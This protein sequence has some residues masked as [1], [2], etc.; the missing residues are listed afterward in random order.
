M[1]EEI[2]PATGP[3][4]PATG[5]K[6]FQVW[7]NAN[8]DDLIICSACCCNWCGVDL[9]CDPGC[10]LCAYERECICEEQRCCLKADIELFPLACDPCCDLECSK[11]G[12]C[13]TWSCL[14]FEYSW[15]NPKV[16]C[17]DRWS[18]LCVNGQT[19]FPPT[20]T[21]PMACI[22]CYGLCYCYPAC[23]VCPSLAKIRRDG[24][25]V[26]MAQQQQGVAMAPPVA[27]AVQA[28]PAA[29][30]QLATAP[31]QKSEV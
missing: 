8:E 10:F 1:S 13:W 14:F 15:K 24:G 11:D 6:N 17:G 22:Q 2:P 28:T 5:V 19:E 3:S 27:V 18:C 23:G 31:I 9:S 30:Q 25:Q 7:K 29:P 12:Y 20:A 26:P 16:C 21:F 4:T